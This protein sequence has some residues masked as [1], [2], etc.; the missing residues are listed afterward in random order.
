MNEF[1]S[2]LRKERAGKFTLR[3]AVRTGSWIQVLSAEEIDWVGTAG[4]YT[5]LHS[6]GRSHLLRET[7]NALE[8]QLDPAHFL[9]IHRSCIVR[10]KC[11][12]ELRA[13]GNR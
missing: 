12:R 10:L 8:H 5:E 13:L 3:L 4:D 11:I 1:C 2:C 9:R 6:N 7:M